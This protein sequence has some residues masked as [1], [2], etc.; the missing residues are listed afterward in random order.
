LTETGKADLARTRAE[1]AATMARLKEQ[2]G[3]EVEQEIFR[4]TAAL[5]RAHREAA[6]GGTI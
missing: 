2:T 6:T 1:H 5:R 3:K 4:S